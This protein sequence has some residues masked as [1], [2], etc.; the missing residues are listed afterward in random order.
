MVEF[1]CFII[2]VFRRWSRRHWSDLVLAGLTLSSWMFA[3][4]WVIAIIIWTA[5][6]TAVVVRIVIRGAAALKRIALCDW[7]RWKQWSCVI[8]RRVSRWWLMRLAG[9]VNAQILVCTQL[10]VRR[11]PGGTSL[12]RLGV[13]EDVSKRFSFEL[14]VKEV[15]R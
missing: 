2:V 13:I 9:S 12:H 10:Q 1:R 15:S 6:A 3:R 8:T 14:L 11:R 5:V 4:K 7:R